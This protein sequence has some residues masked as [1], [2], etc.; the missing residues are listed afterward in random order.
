VTDYTSW[1]RQ[2]NDR[3]TTLHDCRSIGDVK[4]MLLTEVHRAAI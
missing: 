1:S 4:D 2:G 3:S